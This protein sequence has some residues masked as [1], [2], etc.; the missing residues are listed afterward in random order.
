MLGDDMLY[1]PAQYAPGWLGLVFLIVV[2]IVAVGVLIVIFTRPRRLTATSATSP[3]QV[4][5][6]LRTEYSAEIDHVE[7]RVRAGELDAR[8]AHGELSR[9]MRAF[10][11]EYSGIEAPVMTL[12]DLAARGVHP[13][14]VDALGRFSYPSLFRR[15]APVDPLLGVEAARQVVTSWH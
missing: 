8:Q 15:G 11:N 7:Q 3:M 1:P 5:A 4:L 2:A 10:V 12:Q 13:A 6:L 14:L 9:L